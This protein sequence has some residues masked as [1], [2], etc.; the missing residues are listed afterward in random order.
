MNND[1]NSPNAPTHKNAGNF[2]NDR[3]RAAEAGRKGGQASRGGGRRSSSMTN[4]EAAE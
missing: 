1:Q 4:V 3:K 2:A